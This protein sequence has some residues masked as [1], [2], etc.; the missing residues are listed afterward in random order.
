[1]YEELFE[2]CYDHTIDA[3]LMSSIHSGVESS[4]G[5]NMRMDELHAEV[6]ARAKQ[7]GT[8]LTLDGSP[9]DKANYLKQ[10]EMVSYAY[11]DLKVLFY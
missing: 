5:R 10:L 1:M 4:V 8:E 9:E 11:N 2:E 6:L 3:N 7:S